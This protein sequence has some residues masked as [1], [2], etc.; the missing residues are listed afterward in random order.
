MNVYQLTEEQKEQLVGQT[1]DCVQ[2]FNPTLDADGNWFIS[3][4]EVNGYSGEEFTWVK[5]LNEIAHNPIQNEL[6]T[7][8]V[9]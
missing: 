1:Y 8:Q 4:E 5:S 3:V 6:P 9:E 7:Q 2:F